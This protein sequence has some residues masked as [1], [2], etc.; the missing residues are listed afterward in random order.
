MKQIY[1]KLDSRNRISLTKIGKLSPVYRVY[2]EKNKIILEPIAED[3]KALSKE[4]EWL[5]RPEN[6]KLL[7]YVKECLKQEA[8]IDLGSFKKYLK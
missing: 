6:K 5:F 1:V 7:D 3:K 8:N 2:I 4:E